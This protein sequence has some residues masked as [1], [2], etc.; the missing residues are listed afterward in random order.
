MS[1]L[2]AEGDSGPVMS[3]RHSL[4]LVL[5]TTD[6][7][8]FH[9]LFWDGPEPW[10]KGY[11]KDVPFVAEHTTDTLCINHGPLLEAASL[12]RSSLIYGCR[13]I[14]LENILILSI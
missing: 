10:G 14:D 4:A 12:I 8:T 9:F 7:S 3:R 6:S 5:P 13:H 11:S 1:H 2:L